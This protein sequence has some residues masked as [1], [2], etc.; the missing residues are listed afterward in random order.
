MKV[1]VDGVDLY[2]LQPWEIKVLENE[3]ISE[4]LEE[5]CKRRL[6]WVLNH[7][8][9]Q[10]YNR[11]ESQWIDKLRKDPEVTNIPLDEKEFSEMVMAR[12]DYKNRSQREAEAED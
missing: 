5:D 3:L 6:H 11:L 4:T 10:C 2:E 9:K 8:V 7:K 1:Q 12:P